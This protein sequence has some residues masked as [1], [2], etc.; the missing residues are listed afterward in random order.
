MAIPQSQKLGESREKKY[1]RQEVTA[2]KAE[3]LLIITQGHLILNKVLG[4][5][6]YC[7]ANLIRSSVL[8]KHSKL[9]SFFMN[10]SGL[11]DNLICDSNSR[12][13]AILITSAN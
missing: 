8:S 13:F 1:L 5:L 12:V 9:E 4:C 6:S 7:L 3:E 10:Y 11:S 2:S